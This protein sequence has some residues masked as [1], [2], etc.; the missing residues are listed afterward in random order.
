MT[1][2]THFFLNG[3]FYCTKK[4]IDISDVLNYFNYNDSL[5]VVEYNNCICN[6]KDWS[7]I[8]IQ[9]QDRI[10]IVTIVGGG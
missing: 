5:L 3:Q 9:D 10:E 4:A 8:L 7:Q 1:Q 2:I 6:K